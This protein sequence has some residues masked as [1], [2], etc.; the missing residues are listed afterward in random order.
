[1]GD[2]YFLSLFFSYG[3]FNGNHYLNI[4]MYCDCMLDCFV[5]AKLVEGSRNF[6]CR[7]FDSTKEF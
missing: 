3:G 2:K 6:E 1:M 4:I 5:D 7:F